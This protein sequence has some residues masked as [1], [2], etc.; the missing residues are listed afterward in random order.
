MQ[1]NKPLLK[2]K[3]LHDVTFSFSYKL[4]LFKGANISEILSLT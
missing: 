3:L 4:H 2:T 1:I